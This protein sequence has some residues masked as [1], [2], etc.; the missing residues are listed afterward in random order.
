MRL[1][2]NGFVARH[3]LKQNPYLHDEC[4][5]FTAF[6]FAMIKRGF[7]NILLPVWMISGTVLVAGSFYENGLFWFMQLDA[8]GTFASHFI[9]GMPLAIVLPLIFPGFL[10]VSVG[11]HALVFAAIVAA[12][13]YGLIT[14][15]R[16]F[17]RGLEKT[18]E[19]TPLNVVVTGIQN[20]WQGICRPIEFYED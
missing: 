9:N 19:G 13:V 11:I 20:K 4:S 2:K 16:L 17:K 5:L 18:T 8:S 6:I 10:I 15:C 12:I 7:L 14:L 3:A 1:N